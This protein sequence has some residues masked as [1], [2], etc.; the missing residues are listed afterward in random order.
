LGATHNAAAFQAEFDRNV[1]N[2]L[3][4]QYDELTNMPDPATSI[5]NPAAWRFDTNGSRQ[6][7]VEDDYDLRE[8]IFAYYLMGDYNLTPRLKMI[9]GARVEQTEAKMSA[10]LLQDLRANG[11]FA[12][13]PNGP[14]DKSFTNLLPALHLRWEATDKILVRGAFT[15]S[16][17]RPDYKDMAPI[18]RSFQINTGP[19][20]NIFT[21]SLQEGNPSLEP[22]EANNFDVSA[23]YYFAS[24]RGMIMIS[25]FYKDI[26]NAIYDFTYN[27][28]TD[29][30]D[31][32][33]K[34]TPAQPST[35]SRL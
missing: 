22:Y 32:A 31:L 23:A 29:D 2:T 6:N 19:A 33:G 18:G 13:L 15:T 17:G 10:F 21:G 26:K 30:V 12:L 1:G 28:L 8:R 4:E 34:T 11:T 20:S 27:P 24:G 14:V 16:I 25:A 9:A 35:E 3:N 7:S 5:K